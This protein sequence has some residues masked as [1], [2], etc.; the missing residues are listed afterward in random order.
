MRRKR[1]AL[2]EAERDRREMQLAAHIAKSHAFR[3][4]DRIACFLANDGEPRLDA[5]IERIWQL[6]K[7]CYL[8]ILNTF[9]R[10]RLWFALFEPDTPLITNRYGIPEPDVAH[11]LWLRPQQMELVLTPLV[12]FDA[13]GNR[14]GM[15]GG[16]Y[17]RSFAFLRHRKHWRQPRL[18]GVAFD[19]QQVEQ[20]PV[21][22]WDVP[23]YRVITDE[24]EVK[25]GE[26]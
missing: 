8:P 7:Q 23:L 26:G 25:T 20:L 19:F 6:G 24:G 1:R 11:R 21:A 13:Q 15:G 18:T 9:G 10:N 2:P 12:A 17:D 4:A 22:H 14:L 5:I 3:N 16:Y